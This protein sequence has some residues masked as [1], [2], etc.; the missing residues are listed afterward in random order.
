MG[1]VKVEL[2]CR[3]G[4]SKG[5][6]VKTSRSVPVP[7]RCN[8]APTFSGSGATRSIV[9]SCGHRCFDGPEEL[10]QAVEALTERGW[11]EWIRRGAVIVEC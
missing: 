4:E 5:W 2:H 3:C 8:P 7:L 9:C 6:C 10:E 1:L 11:G